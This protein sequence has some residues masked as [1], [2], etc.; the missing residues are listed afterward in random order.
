MVFILLVKLPAYKEGLQHIYVIN[1][2]IY[3]PLFGK[4]G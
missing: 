4:E 3:I 1:I 2:S